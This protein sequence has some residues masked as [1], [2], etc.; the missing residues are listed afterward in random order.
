MTDSVKGDG[1]RLSSRTIFEG[2][3]I[4][5]AVDR[6]LL[7]NGRQHEFEMIRHLGAAAVVPVIEDRVLLIRQ[8]RYASGGWLDEIP[9]GKLD[10]DDPETC[11]RRE[12]VEEIGYRPGELIS[13]GWIWTTPGFTDEKIHLY[14]GQN[15]EPAEQALE[16]HEVIEVVP[17]PLA[18]AV[19]RA[20]RGDITDSKTVCGLLRAASVLANS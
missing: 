9:G 4:D 15:L 11:A 7:P 5:V 19:R 20:A 8:Y 14:L 10:G 1:R 2:R 17:V 3:V 18:E 16:A 12:L 13:L 6:V